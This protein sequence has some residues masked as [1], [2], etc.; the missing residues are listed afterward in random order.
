MKKSDPNYTYKK[1]T[2]TIDKT[3]NP[4]PVIEQVNNA[5]LFPFC[6]NKTI[7]TSFFEKDTE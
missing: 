1:E 2:I 6:P 5:G 7:D 3:H 4:F